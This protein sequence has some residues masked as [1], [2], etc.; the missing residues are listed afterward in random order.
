MQ[1]CAAS[2]V[3]LIHCS[4]PT[5]IQT[6]N[7]SFYKNVGRAVRVE[8]LIGTAKVPLFIGNIATTILASLNLT[9]SSALFDH[10]IQPP[11]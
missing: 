2:Q 8:M 11:L 6:R 9:S 1:A 10:K 5:V 7:V 3:V 4:K